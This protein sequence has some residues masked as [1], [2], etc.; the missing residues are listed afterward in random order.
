[1]FLGL[2]NGCTQ[3]LSC[4]L[5]CLTGCNQLVILRVRFLTASRSSSCLL[6]LLA[7]GRMDPFC[8]WFGMIFPIGTEFSFS[9]KRCLAYITPS[10]FTDVPP[11][12]L[13]PT[14]GTS[15]NL[16]VSTTFILF[17]GYYIHLVGTYGTIWSF[18]DPKWILVW[19]QE[20]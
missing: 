19:S 12:S 13:V 4:L 6:V 9:R 14:S 16:L 3:K 17:W 11:M 5:E 10:C 7:V 8:S 18:Y 1:M 20:G 2:L 15:N